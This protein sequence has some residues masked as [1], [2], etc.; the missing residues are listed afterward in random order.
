MKSYDPKKNFETLATLVERMKYYLWIFDYQ[1]AGKLLEEFQ[2]IG[3]LDWELEPTKQVLRDIKH[4]SKSRN[5]IK[6]QVAL[7]NMFKKIDRIPEEFMLIPL[8]RIYNRY[9]SLI[10]YFK[11][12]PNEFEIIPSSHESGFRWVLFDIDDARFEFRAVIDKAI[13]F[14]DYRK[15]THNFEQFARKYGMQKIRDPYIMSETK[16]EDKLYAHKI[17]FS[18]DLGLANVVA[19]LDGA[20]SAEILAENSTDAGNIAY[21]LLDIYG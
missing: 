1:S 14:Q 7:A 3:L 4:A 11:E 9:K 17:R 19:I 15:L 21:I 2:D 16:T 8:F 5:F 10:V 20:V 18:L 6:R 13:E 12:H